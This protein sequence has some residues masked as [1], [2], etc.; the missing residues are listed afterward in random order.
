MLNYF[1]NLENLLVSLF[2]FFKGINLTPLVLKDIKNIGSLS[3][4]LSKEHHRSALYL[5]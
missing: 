4:K 3:V 5:Y 1:S 2:V